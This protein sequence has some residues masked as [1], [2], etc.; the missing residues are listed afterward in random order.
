MDAVQRMYNKLEAG[1]V[2]FDCGGYINNFDPFLRTSLFTGLLYERL[3][4]KNDTI[5][6]IYRN[7]GQSWEQVFHALLFHYLGAPS[8]IEAFETLADT[9][10]YTVTK[11]Y[12]RKPEKLEALFIGGS[13]LLDL[14]PY[15]EYTH[16][17]RLEFEY[18]SHK[19]NIHKMSPGVWNLERISPYN[20]P[21]LRLSQ[22]VAIFSQP[23]FNIDHILGCR[24]A[25]D[26]ERLLCKEASD[27]WSTHFCP[28]ITSE[29]VPKRIGRDKAH[30]LAINAIVPLLFSH[31][32]YINSD[33]L[34][35]RAINL[36]DD[37]KPENNYKIR[38]W[39]NS[40]F[41]PRSAF[42]TQVLIQLGDTYCRQ[43]RCRECPIGMHIVK[44]LK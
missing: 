22:A 23:D 28:S 29:P 9:I 18:M 35:D 25:A 42:D 24:T 41:I 16:N 26:A 8:N 27:Y 4:R 17:I 33:R 36:L 19:H 40:G 1:S 34:R 15:D 21:V 5:L 39:T 13:G 12:I 10:S 6:N 20:H 14:Y 2:T 30:I 38:S 44:T 32:S 11:L 7:E 3:K 43:Q 37:L 31:G